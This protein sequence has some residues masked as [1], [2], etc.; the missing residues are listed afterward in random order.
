[1]AEGNVVLDAR[2]SGI[3]YSQGG[4][5]NSQIEVININDG[6]STGKPPEI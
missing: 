1:M 2:S 4:R 5:S 3:T 6:K